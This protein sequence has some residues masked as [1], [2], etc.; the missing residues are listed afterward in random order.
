MKLQIFYSSESGSLGNAQR[1]Q[2]EVNTYLS[3]GKINSSISSSLEECD[4]NYFR[5]VL[6]EDCLI[7]TNKEL[8]PKSFMYPEPGDIGLHLEIRHKY[9]FY[10][11]CR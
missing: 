11:H 5:I 9:N 8:T 4:D 1:I 7:W 6:N 3:D 10:K 2:Q